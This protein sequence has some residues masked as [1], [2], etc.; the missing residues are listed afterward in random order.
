MKKFLPYFKLLL[1]VKWKFS[2]AI[3]SGVI[4]GLASG[5][6]LP[7]MTSKVFPLLFSSTQKGIQIAVKEVGVDGE[8]YPISTLEE[9]PTSEKIHYQK[10]NGSEIKPLTNDTKLKTDGSLTDGGNDVS[11][12]KLY[13]KHD[14]KGLIE[15]EPV[16]FL[17]KSDGKY[18]RVVDQEFK[19]D[20]RTLILAVLLLPAVFVIRGIAGFINTYYVTYCGQKVLEQIRSNVFG[21]MQ[22]LDLA[23]FQRSG[24]GDLMVRLMTEAARL[25]QMLTSTSNDAIK[26]PV[27][28]ISAIVALIY[29]SIQNKESIFLLICVTVIPICILPIKVLTKHMLRKMRQGAVGEGEIGNCVQE[30]IVGAR[31]IRSFNLEQAEIQ[32]FQFLQTRFYSLILGMTKYRA[33]VGPSVEIITALGISVAIFFA[34]QYGMTLEK[35]IPLIAAL[36]MS[37]EPMKKIAM[38]QN[39]FV[40]GGVAIERLEEILHTEETLIDP[41]TPKPLPALQGGIS[42]RNVMFRYDTGS[43]ALKDVN[44]NIKPG[45]VVALVG[46]SG[47]G[48]STFTHLISRT[49]EITD[50]KIFFDE[51]DVTE[52]A[53]ADLR[54]QVSVVSQDP[55]LFNDTLRN[56]ILLGK[57]DAS[58]EEVIQAAERANCLDFIRELP[59]G[60][61]TVC[62]EKATLLSGGQR[63]RL[64]IARAFLKDAPILILDEATSAL[65]AESEQTV[66]AALAK[67]VKGRTTLLIAHR[68]SSI[69]IA[70]RILVFDKGQIAADGTHESLLVD[71]PLYK[72]LYKKQNI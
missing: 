63:Q 41:A 6:G 12:E 16:P 40:L 1:P 5:F 57:P 18:E 42:F 10:A 56:N 23:F 32:K 8:H 29:L 66:Q 30:N 15:I 4:Y 24:T 17:A 7:F 67:L 55:Y 39:Q 25:Q 44:V 27:S 22:R 13:Y 36:Y 45:E 43:P 60:F 37:Y 71:S 65:D 46:P 28:F 14:E 53:L 51:S 62:G 49:Y 54:A 64:A 2:I 72:E 61:D 35:V 38:L 52:H 59:E 31:E 9:F 3:L 34:A 19:K 26:Q 47:A 33:M 70:T 50:G 20:I 48:K 58:E 21:K 68:F 11:Y 69:Q